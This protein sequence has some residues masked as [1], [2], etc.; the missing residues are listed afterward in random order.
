[1]VHLLSFSQNICTQCKCFVKKDGFFR[2][3]GGEIHLQ[4]EN[5]VSPV[6]YGRISLRKGA[7][8]HP[9]IR[10]LATFAALRKRI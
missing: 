9:W 2:P 7:K 1:M 6:K 5:R 10:F 4:V 3:A 8:P